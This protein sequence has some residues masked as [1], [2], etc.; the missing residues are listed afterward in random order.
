MRRREFITLLG[1]AAATWPMAARAQQRTLPVIG[2]LHAGFPEGGSPAFD[3]LRAGLRDAG[4]V[5]G[6]TFKLE[7]RWARGRP[8]ICVSLPKISSNFVSIS[9]SQQRVLR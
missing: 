1:G 4:Y 7:A 2:F 3:A 5:E 8:E 9:L 6:D